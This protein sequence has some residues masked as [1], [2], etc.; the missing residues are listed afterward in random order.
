MAV[1]FIAIHLS[2][3]IC[4]CDCPCITSMFLVL[5][6]LSVVLSKNADFG[7]FF[8]LFEL[9]RKY[10]LFR[11]LGA[12]NAVFMRLCAEDETI[13]NWHETDW[14]WHALYKTRNQVAFTG[15]WVRIPPLP[16]NERS[17]FFEH[18]CRKADFF[19]SENPYSSRASG[20]RHL[21][22]LPQNLQNWGTKLL[23]ANGIWTSLFT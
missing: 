1:S 23:P 22:V 12:K 11:G 3:S 10:W 14:S 2:K 16:P 18:F 13:R 17:P 21:G 9:A 6:V 7:A 5:S 4:R 20:F 15:S 19:F 8:G